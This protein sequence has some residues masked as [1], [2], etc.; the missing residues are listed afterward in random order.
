MKLNTLFKPIKIGNLNLKNRIVMSPMAT[1]LVANGEVTQRLLNFYEERAKGGVGLIGVSMTP[2]RLD[3]N[4]PLVGIYDDRFIPGLAHL[5]QVCHRHDSKNFAQLILG[6]CWAF[7][8]R[9]VELISP[10]GVTITGG[11]DPPFRVGGPPRGTSTGRRPLE[12]FEISEMVEACGDAARRIREAG[13][14]G[15]QI[16]ASTGYLVSQF[17]SPLTNKRTDKYGGELENRMRFLLELI[18]NSKK[19]AGEDWTYSVRISPQW[20]KNGIT[21]D[22][23]KQMAVILEKNGVHGIDVLP[24]WHEDPIPFIQSCVP[25]GKWVYLAE[26]VKEAVKIP[27]GAGNQIHDVEI[28]EKA[29]RQGKADYIYMCR[30]LVADPDLPKKAKEGRVKDIR[31]CIAC[32]RCFENV[33]MN[34]EKLSCTVNPMVGREGEYNITPA[35]NSKKVLIIGG[36]PAG[37]EA[38]K[39]A[40]LRGHQVTLYEEKERL[41]GAM[42]V[43][44][45]LEERIEKFVQYMQGK[46]KKWPIMEIKTGTKVTSSMLEEIKPEVVVLATGG[47][48]IILELPGIEGENVISTRDI[49]GVFGRSTFK[50]RRVGPRFLWQFVSLFVKYFYSPSFIRWFLRFPFPFKKRVIIIGGGFAACQ[51][52]QF[53]SRRGKQVTIVEESRHIGKDIGPVNR[54]VIMEELRKGGARIETETKLEEVSRNG[55]KVKKGEISQFLTGDTVVLAKGLEAD[56]KSMKELSRKI[57]T[58]YSIGDCVQPGKIKEAIESG[59]LLGFKV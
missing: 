2:N 54:W 32:G 50:N 29:L 13:F 24:G 58:I 5:V 22:E 8:E 43:A 17:L 9:P 26:G 52:G 33:L 37:M 11:I 39:M 56:N 35:S 41:G 15:I 28:A 47:V 57:A 59:F 38:A 46:S 51:L 23:L 1:N 3:N 53:L 31:P 21:L 42:L 30:A 27:V 7:P 25:Q 49:Q 44:G 14:D 40:S 20:T 48:P 36:G 16:I 6:Y 45:I 19:K 10:S 34:E 18:K 12:E 4:S 55:V